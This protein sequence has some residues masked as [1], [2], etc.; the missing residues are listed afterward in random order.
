MGKQSKF[1]N[2]THL[3]GC[4]LGLTAKSLDY[5]LWHGESLSIH[6]TAHCPPS[7]PQA[8][9]ARKLRDLVNDSK[10]LRS[11]MTKIRQ[12]ISKKRLVMSPGVRR[13]PVLLLTLLPPPPPPTPPRFLL[14]HMS[15]PQ[16]SANPK[17]YIKRRISLHSF[18]LSAGGGK[19]QCCTP[20][21]NDE[22]HGQLPPLLA[23]PG[24]PGPPLC[25]LS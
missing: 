13:C 20:Q 9:V 25:L 5:N 1:A 17:F 24:T 19:A 22:S 4:R 23:T 15:T 8:F 3:H 14:R 12:Q 6:S 2:S 11:I 18:L 21:F 7:L 16:R 10:T